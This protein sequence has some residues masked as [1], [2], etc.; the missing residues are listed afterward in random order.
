M[1][2]VCI[3]GAWRGGGVVKSRWRTLEV[4]EL[5]GKQARRAFVIVSGMGAH[6]ISRAG[7]EGEQPWKARE[8]S[9]LT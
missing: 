5:S 6:A 7:K 1:K 8:A 9:D 2:W 4:Q 3:V